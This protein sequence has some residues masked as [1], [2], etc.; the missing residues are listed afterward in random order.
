[1]T[2]SC[3]GGASKPSRSF[4]QSMANQGAADNQGG[5]KPFTRRSEIS[6]FA[7]VGDD[8]QN[9]ARRLLRRN[10]AVKAGTGIALGQQ[11]R[12]AV[13]AALPDQ[14]MDKRITLPVK[15][16][17]DFAEP[18]QNCGQRR[19]FDKLAALEL[20]LHGAAG[21]VDAHGNALPQQR[22]DQLKRA[23]IADADD[24]SGAAA[25]GGAGSGQRGGQPL[26]R[27]GC[28]LVGAE[29]EFKH[30]HGL[31]QR[32]A[33]SKALVRPF[34]AVPR[35]GNHLQQAAQACG[36]TQFGDL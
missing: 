35:N 6:G 2:S 22:L 14:A 20:R 3:E 33:D 15:Q 29:G 26:D 21:N 9:A 32:L 24:R 8:P 19:D 36:R 10:E 30:G 1:M 31:N 17:N 7:A 16:K 34:F 25:H 4:T 28:G 18:R 12:H 23:R 27:L 11:M 13:L 5:A